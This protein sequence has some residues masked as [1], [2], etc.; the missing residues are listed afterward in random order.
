MEIIVPSIPRSMPCIRIVFLASQSHAL[1]PII[2]RVMPPISRWVDRFEKTGN[3][4]RRSSKGSNVKFS[5]EQ[6]QWISHYIMNHPLSFL[7]ETRQAFIMFWNMKIRISSV[8]S[9]G[10]CKFRIEMSFDSFGIY[11]LCNGLIKP[12]HSSMKSR[13]KI[14]ECF[15]DAAMLSRDKNFSSVESSTECLGCHYDASSTGMDWSKRS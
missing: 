15:E 4:S 10:R 6:R 7:D 1:P 14:E 13:L 8:L 11:L 2:V 9:A 3:L 12:S 5:Q